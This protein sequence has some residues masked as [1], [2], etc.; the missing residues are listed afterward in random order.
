MLHPA[1]LQYLDAP[2]S[3]C[4]TE[5]VCKEEPDYSYLG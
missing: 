5:E 3:Y 4:E 1:L 2:V